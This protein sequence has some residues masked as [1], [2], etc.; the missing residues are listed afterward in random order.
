MFIVARK[1]Y[2]Y[3]FGIFLILATLSSPVSAEIII[4]SLESKTAVLYTEISLIEEDNIVIDLMVNPN[5]QS[6]NIVGTYIKYSTTTLSLIDVDMSNSLCKF[7]I[8][9]SIDAKIGGIL[10][11]CGL[12][13]PGISEKS[14]VAKLIFKKINNGILKIAPQVESMVLANDGLGTNILKETISTSIFIE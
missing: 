9:K 12:P 14:Q 10:I 13:S 11:I 4:E 3:L 1:K 7:T 2:T 6:I 8:E 5:N